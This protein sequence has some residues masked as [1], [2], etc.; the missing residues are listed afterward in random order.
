MK[1]VL[2]YEYLVSENKSIENNKFR[3]LTTQKMKFS[4]KDLLSKCEVRITEEILSAVRNRK[5]TK[6]FP[7]AI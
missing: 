2:K 6:S 1:P 3:F 5:V 7:F 4:I